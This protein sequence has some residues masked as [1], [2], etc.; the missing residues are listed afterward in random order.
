MN[1]VD[2]KLQQRGRETA[3][4]T[5][6]GR[7]HLPKEATTRR[8][9]RFHGGGLNS[10]CSAAQG[11]REEAEIDDEIEGERFSRPFREVV[12]MECVRILKVYVLWKLSRTG[13]EE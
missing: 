5:E 1:R 2:S 4:E 7:E 9:R 11:P 3:L 10:Q 12:E 8:Q 13:T 6:E